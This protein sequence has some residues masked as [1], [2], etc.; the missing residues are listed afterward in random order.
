M[1]DAGAKAFSFVVDHVY[2]EEDIAEKR[3]YLT[4]VVDNM[5][6]KPFSMV[7]G[8]NYDFLGVITSVN[9]KE[10]YITVDNYK[11][12][13]TNSS[14]II[15]DNSYIL[16]PYDRIDGSDNY[17][18][19]SQYVNEGAH[20]LGDTII[21][22][23]GVAFGEDNHVLTIGSFS[24]GL[25]NIS[26]GKYS[27]T[28]GRYNV[29]GYCDFA[30]GQ[31]MK[32]LGHWDVW[33]G[34]DN[35]IANTS[36]YSLTSGFRNEIYN[37]YC[38]AF[39]RGHVLKFDDSTARGRY[40]ETDEEY[41]QRISWEEITEYSTKLRKIKEFKKFLKENPEIKSELLND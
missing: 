17:T 9:K 41:N 22:D 39:G 2:T 3:Y 14:T 1:S 38:S 27:G 36:D 37:K 6:N 29:T 24:A 28:F 32:L 33:F 12:P 23:G 19:N 10:K 16:L 35:F 11:T 40:S 30:F 8:E 21:G 20:L 13:N 18:W 15:Y 34:R 7:L 25:S 4:Y 31:N 26:A 5:V